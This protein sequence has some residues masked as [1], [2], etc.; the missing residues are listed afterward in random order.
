MQQEQ[1]EA[2]LA[3]LAASKRDARERRQLLSAMSLTM[4][5]Q[6]ALGAQL[7]T[8]MLTTSEESGG[9]EDMTDLLGTALDEARMAQENQQARGDAFLSAIE[10][11]LELAAAEG[12]LGLSQRLLFASIWASYEL[13]APRV[14]Q[15]SQAEMDAAQPDI[16]QARAAEAM[17]D[18]HFANLEKEAGGDV[19]MLHAALGEGFPAMPPELRDFVVQKT[20]LRP[21]DIYAELG[22]YWLLDRE[23]AIRLAAA[24]GLAKRL[25]AGLL[26][27]E[28]VARLVV[29]R[30]WMPQDSAR[31]LLDRILRD[32]LRSGLTAATSSESWEVHEVLASLPDGGGAQTVA[33]S[34]R[35]GRKRKVAMVLLK[36][37]HGVKDAF[38]IP[39]SSSRDLKQFLEQVLEETDA[40]KVPPAWLEQ[41]LAMALAEGLEAGRPP[42]VGLIEIARLCGLSDLRPQAQATADLLEEP[43][44]RLEIAALSPQARG[45]L[46][47]RSGRWP[48]RHSIVDSW[49]EESDRAHELL[50]QPKSERAREADLW[51]LLETRRD[52]WTRMLA[53]SAQLLEAAEHPDAPAFVAT[54]QALLEGRS[55]KKTPV[56]ADVHERTIGV[57]L[58]SRPGNVP[59]PLHQARDAAMEPLP[60]ESQD[61]A[62][63]PLLHETPPE[64][65][66]EFARLLKGAPI[67]AD[68]IDGFLMGAILAPKVVPPNSW[69]SAILDMVATTFDPNKIDRF[70]EL[71]VIRANGALQQA[72]SRE[73]FDKA[74]AKRSKKAMGNWAAGFSHSHDHFHSAWPSRSLGADDRALI[75]LIARTGAQ[76]F[77]KEDIKLLGQWVVARDEKNRRR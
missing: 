17:I 33:I 22:I 34:L 68:W 70:L 55:L 2:A 21:G 44:A 18:Q 24:R 26:T 51:R 46:I 40:L 36:Q 27:A 72:T 15:L 20:V 52:W 45:R 60:P 1:I 30:S 50:E 19:F 9:L 16:A 35:S 66:G 6:P 75:Q 14:L 39:R 71:M 13:Q 65:R 59:Y 7:V 57:W 63:E 69:V 53:L 12:R 28:N 61:A 76:G 29:L 10:E 73:A 56:M 48:R 41:T 3:E 43:A 58:S 38:I 54:A 74:M 49:F 64:R 62:L 5:R 77:T 42:A 67:T 32:A 23:A 37:R 8:H 4:L 47:A 25:E 11:A 31:E